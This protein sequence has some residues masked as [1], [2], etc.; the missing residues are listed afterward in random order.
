MMMGG[1]RFGIREWVAFFFNWKFSCTV[2]PSYFC[3]SLPFSSPGQMGKG[4]SAF[5]N[6]KPENMF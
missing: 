5:S 4:V 1:R 6:M 3:A 2:F